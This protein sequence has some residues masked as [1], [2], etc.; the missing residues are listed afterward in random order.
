LTLLLLLFAASEQLPRFCW[1]C[2]FALS[3]CDTQLQRAQDNPRFSTFKL[4]LQSIREAAKRVME[5]M[6]AATKSPQAG[7]KI[8][9]AGTTAQRRASQSQPPTKTAS[10]PSRAGVDASASSSV[11]QPPSAEPPNVTKSKPPA[12]PKPPRKPPSSAAE[13]KPDASGNGGAVPASVRGT[14]GEFDDDVALMDLA[15]QK[16]PS[17]RKRAPATEAA[18]VGRSSAASEATQH[19]S[20]GAAFSGLLDANH[21]PG[22]PLKR[23]NAKKTTQLTGDLHRKFS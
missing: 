9:S 7:E 17:K 19:A 2:M 15:Q 3:G 14:S 18:A 13:K 16:A 10:A 23:I 12:A 8:A 4:S 5:V 22:T 11:P 6:L 20:N 1:P 21:S